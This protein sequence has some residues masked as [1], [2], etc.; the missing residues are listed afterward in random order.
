MPKSAFTEEDD[1]LLGELG[2][3]VET[4]KPKSLT[5]RE[6]RI[7]AGFEDILR[8]YEENGR[9]PEHGEGNDIF[10]RMYAVRL[11]RLRQL[12]E[13]RALLEPLDTQG[14]LGEVRPESLAIDE[15]IDD[16]T[17]L[18]QLGVEA[19]TVDI[20]DLKHV[21]SSA[22]KRA[23]EEIANRER[24]DDFEAFKPLFDQV[25]NE[26]KEGVRQSRVIRKEA[27][28]LKTDIREGQFFI[29]DGQTLYVADV[30][31][32]IKAPNGEMDARLRVIFSNGT[33]SNL[34]LRSL[35]RAIYKDESSR[36]ISD[37]SAGPLFG[38]TSEED[39]L[40]SGTIYVLRSKSNHPVV[41]ENREVLH[42]IGVTGG[43]VEKR[44]ANA[45]KDAT[46]LLADVEVVATYELFNINR[47]K[48]EQLMHRVFEPA[49]LKISIKDRFGNPVEPRE[50]FLVPLFVIDDAIEK[51]KDG[52]IGEYLYD[53][54]EAK[55]LHCLA[56]H[57]SE[58]Q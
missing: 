36:H 2:V 5:P 9:E 13:C 48:F 51:F 18:E 54:N 3:E 37:P 29:L 44:I 26:L 41:D 24:C 10:E 1:A 35:Q 43:S 34:L 47:T 4:K 42:K 22:E 11:D 45:A 17:L 8:F 58:S 55:L 56:S 15:D 30:G 32:T 6:E 20:T 27:G 19:E 23:A 38:D 7:I 50:W 49:R 25:Q 14:L 16:D 46:Y 57:Q 12:D 33:E 39:D 31:E 52:T 53:P 40:A 28:F 21:R